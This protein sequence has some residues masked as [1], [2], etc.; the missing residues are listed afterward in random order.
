MEDSILKENV[1]LG[2]VVKGAIKVGSEGVGT[3]ALGTATLALAAATS[4][5][6]IYSEDSSNSVIMV[7]IMMGGLMSFSIGSASYALG[8]KTVKD[9]KK[10]REYVGCYKN[11]V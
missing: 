10:L 9:Y 8:I 4:S 1:T 2:D 5:L 3:V 11:R 6:M 7:G